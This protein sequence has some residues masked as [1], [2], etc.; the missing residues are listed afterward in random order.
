MR[1]KIFYLFLILFAASCSNRIYEAEMP[2]YSLDVN[3]RS[4]ASDFVDSYDYVM[5]ET[6]DSVVIGMIDRLDMNDSIISVKSRECVYSFDYTGK[7]I[8]IVNRRGKGSGEYLGI[9]DF[10][11]HDNEIWILSDMNK[12]ILVYDINGKLLRELILD[13]PYYSFE[14]MSD[15]AV[16]LCSINCNDKKKN[17]VIVDSKTGEE[18]AAFDDFENNESVVLNRV[19]ATILGNEDKDMFYVTH[20]FDPS[21]YVVTKDGFEKIISL[22]FNTEMQL[23]AT[24]GQDSFFNIM[25]ATDNK[26]VV[27]YLS[28]Y[29][30][31]G[32]EEILS[33]PLFGEYGILG[34]M[35]KFKNGKQVA[36]L[37][38]AAEVDKSFPYLN[39]PLAEYKGR[40][41]S[42]LIP[43][44]I[45]YIEENNNLSKFKDLGLKDSDNPVIFFHRLK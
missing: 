41:V 5:L 18:I 32:D 11:L 34:N 14:I 29:T 30:K 19:S 22:D 44:N 3:Q 10:H 13:A 17:F 6:N 15:D 36:Y 9:A 16:L 8:G 23:P 38:I 1:I 31:K 4:Q 12:K 25:E 24:Y 21:I 37:P 2:L 33:F 45:K 40:F 26:P 27:R 43:Y 7:A 28:T 35:V 20:Q 42:V 39:K